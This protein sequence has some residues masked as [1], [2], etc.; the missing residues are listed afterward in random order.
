MSDHFFDRL[1][2][3]Y[4]VPYIIGLYAALNCAVLAVDQRPL[5]AGKRRERLLHDGK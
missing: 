3:V 4:R 2:P 1:L 5:E